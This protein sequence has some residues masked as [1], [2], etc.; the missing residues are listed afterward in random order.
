MLCQA[1]HGASTF[2]PASAALGDW[3][4]AIRSNAPTAVS[5]PDSRFPIPGSQSIL[6]SSNNGSPITPL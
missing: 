6:A 1:P 2:A 3:S 4:F 5:I